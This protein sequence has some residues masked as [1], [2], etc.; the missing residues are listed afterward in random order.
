MLVGPLK[1]E[2]DISD[3]EFGL[4]F[5]GAFAIIYGMLGLPIARLVDRGN[6]KFLIFAGVVLWSFCT[7]SS[8]LATSFGMLVILRVGLAI[9]EAVLSPA[10][11]SMIGDMFPPERRS[12]PAAIYAA[13]GN[14]GTYGAYVAGAGIFAVISASPIASSE[15][16]SQF[17]VW[18]IVFFLVGIPGMLVAL[19]FLTSTHEPP[20]TAEEDAGLLNL[21][22]ALR[23]FLRR[24]RLFAGLFFGASFITVIIFAYGA[25]TPE[26]FHRS[27]GW[28][29]ED[30]ALAYGSIG[31]FSSALG[32]LAFTHFAERLTR[33]GRSD[34]IVISALVGAIVGSLA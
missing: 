3:F 22:A 28:A 7:F 21:G 10:A 11:Y 29:V 19:I 18:Q 14:I 12:L 33:Q 6:R 13:A 30:A 8:G 17:A 24:F 31:V 20:R 2:F 34:G 16:L 25:W 23:F 4:L 26:F 27:F 1:S 32:T 9:G 15:L 5:G